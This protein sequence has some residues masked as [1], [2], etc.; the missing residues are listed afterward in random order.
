MVNKELAAIMRD[1]KKRINSGWY[2]VEGKDGR[3][4]PFRMNW[5]Q[6]QFYEEQHDRNIILKARQLGFSTYTEIDILDE[7][8]FKPNVSAGIIAQTMDDAKGLLYNKVLFAYKNL[9]QA[10]RDANPLIKENTEELLFSNG[11]SIRVGTSLRGGTY[12]YLHISEFGKIC[13]RFPDRAREIIT[14]ALNTVAIGG[15]IIIESTAE[16]NEGR[17]YSM[18]QTAMS[19]K[20]LGEVLT[21]LDFKFHFFPWWEEPGYVMNGLVSHP[22][23]LAKYYRTL[24]IEHGIKLSEGQKAWYTKMVETQ[25]QDMGREYPSTP[26]EAFAA[27]I[28]GAYYGELM[29]NAEKSGRVVNVPHNEEYEVITAWD[30][31]VGDQTTIWAYQEYGG[32]I[33]VLNYYSNSGESVGHYAKIIKGWADTYGYKYSHHNFPHDGRN[34]DWSAD[35]DRRHEI[36]EKQGIK[37]VQ[38][39]K[40]TSDIQLGIDAV[41]RMIPRCYFDKDLTEQGRKALKN[42]RR[43]YNAEKKAFSSRP[44]HDWASDGADAFRTA[45]MAPKLTENKGFNAPLVMPKLGIA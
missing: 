37:P 38:L 9:P 7:C 32:A 26:E 45:A 39:V 8:M 5:A 1:K 40:R 23:P 22:A 33:Y 18:T 28:E 29:A 25:D 19:K 24:E 11:S 27:A 15:K 36:A 16:G 42:Y 10:L 14:G 30:I 41:R 20:N 44:L 17:F 13:A 2:K 6:D 4:I 43:E 35:G 31:G 12:Q 3:V 34:Q 21:P